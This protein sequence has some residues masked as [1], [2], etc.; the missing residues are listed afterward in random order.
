M[1]EIYINWIINFVSNNLSLEW[2]G[3]LYN[4]IYFDHVSYVSFHSFPFSSPSSSCFSTFY[5]GICTLIPYEGGKRQCIHSDSLMEMRSQDINDY[6]ISFTHLLISFREN[7]WINECD[8]TGALILFMVLLL[9]W[10]VSHMRK[11]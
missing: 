9:S 6:L 2:S 7:S 3:N 1:E 8:V 5:F 11:Y 10:K 4:I